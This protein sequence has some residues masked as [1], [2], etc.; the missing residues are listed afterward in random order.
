MLKQ[1]CLKRSSWKSEKEACQ[2]VRVKKN[3]F[4]PR[5]TKID[6]TI[7]LLNAQTE[8]TMIYNSAFCWI[9]KNSFFSFLKY[10][11]QLVERKSIKDKK[12]FKCRYILALCGE[13][14]VL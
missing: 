6:D 10:R 5:S 7:V 13:V 9:K 3:K 1:K 14:L 12:P 4:W 2:S 11:V 8:S